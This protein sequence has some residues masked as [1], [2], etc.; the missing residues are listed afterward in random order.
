M[1]DG[2]PSEAVVIAVTGGLLGL[3]QLPNVAAIAFLGL[4]KS[5]ALNYNHYKLV[6]L[7]D[8]GYWPNDSVG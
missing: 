3:W 7:I 5:L 1:R 8:R 4:D 2:P 6:V